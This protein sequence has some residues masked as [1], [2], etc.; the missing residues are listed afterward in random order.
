VVL[1]VCGTIERRRAGHN[2]IGII[3]IGLE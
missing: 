3:W 1:V 2:W